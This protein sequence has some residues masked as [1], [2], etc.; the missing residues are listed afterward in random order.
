MKIEVDRKKLE[1]KRGGKFVHLNPR[2]HRVLFQLLDAKGA[3][4]TRQDMLE[5]PDLQTRTVDQHISF[6]RRKL[7]A[8]S[9]ITVPC[10]GYKLPRNTYKEVSF[11]WK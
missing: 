6:L 3:V 5:T 7:G 9:V 2:E 1:V 10:F 11:R 8:D 4:V